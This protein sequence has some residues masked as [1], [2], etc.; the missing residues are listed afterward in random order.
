MISIIFQFQYEHSSESRHYQY[1]YYHS[2]HPSFIHSKI[3][4]LHTASKPLEYLYY[5]DY[6][7]VSLPTTE[8]TSSG[9]SRVNACRTI[10]LKH[11][12]ILNYRL[13][14]EELAYQLFSIGPT[15]KISFEKF[16][17][18]NQFFHPLWKV[19][20]GIFSITD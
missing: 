15:K 14:S 16:P 12:L 2:G 5:K 3:P 9:I 10:A 1:P 13:L 19:S 7:K 18:I 6:P 11:Q 8:P 4:G 20:S 17:E